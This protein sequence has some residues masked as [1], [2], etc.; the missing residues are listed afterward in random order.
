MKSEKNTN[1]II[2]NKIK[3]AGLAKEFTD[4]HKKCNESV[5][6]KPAQMLISLIAPS[7]NRKAFRLKEKHKGKKEWL[8]MLLAYILIVPFSFVMTFDYMVNGWD[9]MIINTLFIVALL[10]FLLLACIP[11]LKRFSENKNI[12]GDL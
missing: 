9:G 2:L 7:I 3:D 4:F 5:P 12:K 11:L 1:R 8:I 10:S 6:D